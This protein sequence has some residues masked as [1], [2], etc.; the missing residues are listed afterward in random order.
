LA[1]YQPR[2]FYYRKARAAGLGSRAAFKI[3]EILKR[4]SLAAPG[5]RVVDLGCAPGGWLTMLARAVGPQGRIVGV[6]LKPCR[7]AAAQVATLAADLGDP[8][9]PA[10]I[11]AVLG[12]PADL[13]TSDAAPRLSGIRT[14]DQAQAAELATSVLRLV[15]K[16]LKPGG[17][18]VVKVFMGEG[19]DQCVAGFRTEFARVELGRTRATRP[20]SSELFVV[21][22]GFRTASA[23]GQRPAVV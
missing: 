11:L 23:A 9:L 13:V 20:G 4:W 19:L 3:E 2:D 10:R 5:A 17:A 1:R 15:R 8:E 22:V 6:D 14:R 12:G 21:A 16:L 18:A 7:P